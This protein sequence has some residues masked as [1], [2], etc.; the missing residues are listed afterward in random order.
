MDSIAQR[1][2]GIAFEAMLLKECFK[3]MEKE[4]DA[5]GGYGMELLA[6]TIAQHDERGFGA[7][8]AARLNERAK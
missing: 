5:V 2:A 4:F 7:M 6:Q 8:L 1:Q 3:P